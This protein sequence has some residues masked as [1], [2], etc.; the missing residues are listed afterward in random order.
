MRSVSGI[1]SL[2]NVMVDP[3]AIATYLRILLE[4]GEL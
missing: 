3:K 4:G 1:I 2:C